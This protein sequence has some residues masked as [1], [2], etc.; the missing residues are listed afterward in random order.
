MVSS[1]AT[2]S[3]PKPFRVREGTDCVGLLQLSLLQSH[4]AHQF[5]ACEASLHNK[6]SDTC[7]RAGGFF[8]CATS[9]NLNKPDLGMV[10]T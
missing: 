6:L 4:L 5:F 10:S 8:G 3:A 1:E 2:S 9:A 7:P